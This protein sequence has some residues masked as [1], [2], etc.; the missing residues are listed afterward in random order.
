MK[1]GSGILKDSIQ[2]SK[3]EDFRCYNSLVVTDDLAF[4]LHI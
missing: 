2:N 3:D 1:L 4:Q